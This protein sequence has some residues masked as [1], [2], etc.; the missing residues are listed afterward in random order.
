VILPF[1]AIKKGLFLLPNFGRG[2]FTPVYI[3]DL[4]NGV[5]LVLEDKRA[6]GE[7]FLMSAGLN[8]TCRDFFSYYFRMLD[9]RGPIVLPTQ[10]AVALAAVNDRALRLTGTRSESNS[11]SV[12]FF[13]RRG[14]ISIAK[15]REVLGY[16]PTVSLPD[17]MARTEAW[18]RE[19]GYLR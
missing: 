2:L 9:K 3:D 19:A 16:N 5:E 18:L 14:G 7:T 10:A 4:V 15:A 13:T 11:T 8:T 1:E 12:R 6:S 17:G